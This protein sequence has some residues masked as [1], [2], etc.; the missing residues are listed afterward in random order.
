M[1]S[2]HPENRVAELA[3]KL[4]VNSMMAMIVCACC[5]VRARGQEA[6]PNTTNESS[7]ATTQVSTENANPTRTTESHSTSGNTSVDHLTL[8]QLGANGRYL[9]EFETEKETV[10]VDPSTTRTVERTYKWDA[11]GQKSL[12]QVKE[13]TRK[14]GNGEA[15]VVRTTSNSD[16]EGKLQVIQRENADTKETGPDTQ[17]TKTTMYVLGTNGALTP[18]LQTQEQQTRGAENSVQTNTT[19]LLPDSS[20]AWK[21]G[22]VKESTVKQDGKNRTTEERV[23]SA[24]LE[25]HFSDLSRTVSQV[26]EIAPGEEKKTVDTYSPALPGL[27]PDGSLHLN[28]R[29]T[30]V[31][32]KDSAGET[33]EQ[34]VEQPNLDEPRAGLQVS[35]TS[36]NV[37]Q[38]S[39]SGTEQTKTIEVRDINGTL[40]LATIET[41]KSDQVPAGE[42]QTAPSG[43]PQ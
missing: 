16:A 4:F 14:S 41:Q 22:E 13:E 23:S 39:I 31:Q 3:A 37:V 1:A 10:Q 38:Y 6:Q 25:G 28:R 12:M 18:S 8:E 26:T 15:H 19:T 36:K 27:P 42:V 21:V 24:D 20:G 32:K 33:T 35:E 30:T 17:E 11:N 7:T 2:S 29:I 43:K 5:V 9:P 34:Q 40:N